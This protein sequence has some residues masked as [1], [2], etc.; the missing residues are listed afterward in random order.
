VDLGLVSF[1]TIAA[2][3][4]TVETVANPRFLR[5]AERRLIRTQRQ[6]CRRHKGSKNRAKARLRVAVAHRRVRDR[7]TDHHHKLAVRLIRENQA[8]AV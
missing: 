8:I 4:G 5:A 6:L 7:R 3:D 1:A 2:S